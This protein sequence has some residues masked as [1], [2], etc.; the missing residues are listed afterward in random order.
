VEADSPEE[1]AQQVST[2]NVDVPGSV[3]TVRRDDGSKPPIRVTI[4]SI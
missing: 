2:G 3:Y 4:G 1:A